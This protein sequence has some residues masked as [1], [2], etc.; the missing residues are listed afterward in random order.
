MSH[1]FLLFCPYLPMNTKITFADWE[2]GPLRCFENR[3]ATP[4]FKS[5]ATAFLS[6][7]VGPEAVSKPI[8]NPALLCRKNEQLDGQRPPDNEIEALKLSLSF[9][10]VDSNPRHKVEQRRN[11]SP[12]VTADNAEFYAWPIDVEEGHV[13]LDFGYIARVQIGGYTIPELE[14]RPPLDLHI[15]LCGVN[16]DPKVL[17][18]IY[19]TVLKS[20]NCPGAC[21]TRDQIRIAVTLFEKAWR[22]T[23]TLHWPERLV[24][25]NTAF[26]ALT[27]ESGKRTSPHE[28]AC[29]LREIFEKVPD[30]TEEHSEVLLWS[31]EEKSKTRCWKSRKGNPCNGRKTD[32]E[33]WFLEFSAVRNAIVHEGELGQDEFMYPR[34][35]N[36]YEPVTCR[37]DYHGPFFFTAEYLLRGAVKVLLS[38]ELCYEVALRSRSF[39]DY[40]AEEQSR[41]DAKHDEQ[42]A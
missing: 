13:T 2:L 35:T 39:L 11:M 25:L 24:F 1:P 22:N 9:A 20:R 38:T 21:P 33:T 5:Q 26:E 40:F 18:G 23:A 42:K 19:E 30:A 32:L 3:W 28:R 37:T 12:Y 6:K 4:E 34:P 31:P 15:P 41:R 17:T 7:F 14:I 10:F 36:V 8:S 27:A 29:R 16:A